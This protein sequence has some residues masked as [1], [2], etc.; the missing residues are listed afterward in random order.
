MGGVGKIFDIDGEDNPIGGVVPAKR[1]IVINKDDPEIQEHFKRICQERKETARARL[2]KGKLKA[3]LSRKYKGRV[4][5]K[6]LQL[7]AQDI[8]VPLD[9]G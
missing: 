9:F 4:A 8:N 5:E 3:L 2:T 1:Q 6:I 7:F